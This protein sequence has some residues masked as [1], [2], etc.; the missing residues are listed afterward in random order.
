MSL[1]S[2]L[3]N[4]FGFLDID[5][6]VPTAWDK[7]PWWEFEEYIKRLNERIEKENKHN[8]DSNQNIPK[9]PN[10]PNIPNMNSIMNKYK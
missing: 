5:H 10:I 8:N 1:T 4:K 3:D 7:I 9:L 6:I 2:I